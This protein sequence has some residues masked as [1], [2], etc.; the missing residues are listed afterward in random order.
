MNKL[1]ILVCIVA[2]IA[3]AA[4]FLIQPKPGPA[5]QPSV[6]EAY[7]LDDS[8]NTLMEEELEKISIDQASFNTQVE[9]EIASSISIFYW[10]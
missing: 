3:I 4:Y 5:S 2:L 9:D 10:E 8:L 6:E 1:I 7:I